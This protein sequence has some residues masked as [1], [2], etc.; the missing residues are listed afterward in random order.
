[1]WIFLAGDLIAYRFADNR[2]GETPLQV[3]GGTTG[4]FVID[5]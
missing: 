1:V 2:S 3:L 4:T 5:G